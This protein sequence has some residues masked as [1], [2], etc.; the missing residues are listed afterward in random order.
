M[1]WN[2]LKSKYN[3]IQIN[4]HAND[5]DLAVIDNYFDAVRDSI[6]DSSGVLIFW[7]P[8]QII[9]LSPVKDQLDNFCK[10]ITNPVVFCTGLLR[11][12][13]INY[14]EYESAANWNS[15]T[16]ELKSRG[17]KF[18]FIGTKDYP[19]RK[20]ILSNIITHG[21]L[22]QGHVSYT[23]LNTGGFPSQFS[24]EEKEHVAAVADIA[25]SYL[26][27]PSLDSKNGY[28]T[29]PCPVFLDCYLNVVTETY[30]EIPD[31]C[32][33]LSEKIYCAIASG[34]M[35]IASSPPGTL[36]Y[37]RSKGYQTFGK[38]IDES[39]DN[40]ENDY[41]R[42]LAVNKSLMEFISQP[43]EKIHEIYT[44]CFP[45]IIHN[46][47]TLTNNTYFKDL[48]SIIDQAYNEKI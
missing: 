12:G 39:Y 42:L 47:N 4:L 40:I 6:K 26:P 32:T 33:F 13:D 2:D 7:A 24:L 3:F 48:C 23:Q 16:I 18:S 41:Q 10:S 29:M 22:D 43:I 35:F 36:Q 34:Q 20:F 37:L 28:F 46:K 27:L 8:G 21:Y 9:S 44:E 38:Y 17:K 15:A 11:P 30:I 19:I 14:F 25:D 45:I 5:L 1:P 31:N